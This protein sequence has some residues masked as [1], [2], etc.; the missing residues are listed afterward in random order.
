MRSIADGSME[1][2]RGTGRKEEL[3]RKKKRMGSKDR[4]EEGEKVKD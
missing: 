3:R 1:K 4:E 2:T